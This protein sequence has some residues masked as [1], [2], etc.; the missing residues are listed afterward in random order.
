MTPS[1]RHWFGRSCATAILGGALL[2]F[3]SRPSAAS[4]SSDHASRP[5]PVQPAEAAARQV[6]AGDRTVLLRRTVARGATA[7]LW[8]WLEGSTS[9]NHEVRTAVAVELVDRLGWQAW[10]QVLAISDPALR[11]KLSRELLWVFGERDPWKAYEEWKLHRGK[12]EDPEWGAGAY[13]G[14]LRAAATM[15][16]GKL[17]EILE[18]VPTRKGEESQWLLSPEYPPG[19]D[20]EEVLEYLIQAPGQP[21]LVSDGLLQEWSKQSPAEVAQ[22]LAANPQAL[23]TEYLLDEATN[24]FGEMIA[25]GSH[26]TDFGAILDSLAGLPAAFIDG[27]WD[28]AV[29]SAEGKLNASTLAAADR[30][31][32]RDSYLVGSLLETRYQQEIDPSWH[33]LPS[34]ERQRVLNLAE[35]RWAAEE[36]SVVQARAR[37]RWRQR[38]TAAW[39]AAR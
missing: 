27:V 17:V 11:E 23:E 7:D 9:E 12:F 32:K 35:Q 20:F 16:A 15:S 18:E 34:E 8:S 4:L 36:P 31:A 3:W 38:V 26:E 29:I 39:E 5:E 10:R 24:S 19:F 6:E 13:E 1:Q 2:G 28:T 25:S 14:A 37:D 30:M 22:W 33:F 21:V